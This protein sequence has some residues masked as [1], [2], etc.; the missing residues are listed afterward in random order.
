[1]K[2]KPKQRPQLPSKV[3]NG[4]GGAIYYMVGKRDSGPYSWLWRISTTGTSFYIK[5][6]YER[7]AEVKVSLHGPHPNH[8]DPHFRLGIDRS[9][10]EKVEG[11]GSI[12]RHQRNLPLRFPGIQVA[13]GVRH[14]VRIRNTWDLFQ[15]QSQSAPIH[16]SVRSRNLYTVGPPPS[17]LLAKDLDL[18]IS[19]GRPYWPRPEAVLR[20]DAGLGPLKN[21]AGQYLT[22][23]VIHQ[24]TLRHP[25]PDGAR[26]ER[27]STAKVVARRGFGSCVDENGLLWLVEQMLDVSSGSDVVNSDHVE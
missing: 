20:D 14:A 9:A 11:L 1:M 23:V 10:T 4:P 16:D 3:P 2:R 24:M 7:F 27:Q 25:T 26:Q 8:N 21:K 17:P 5:A 22:A 15:W 19:D 12:F 18:Y 13:P 6:A